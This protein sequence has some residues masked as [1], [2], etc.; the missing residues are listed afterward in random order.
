MTF[1]FV[2]IY[3]LFVHK[4]FFRKIKKENGSESYVKMILKIQNKSQTM[5]SFHL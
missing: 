5:L 1:S 4:F 3:L 2:T